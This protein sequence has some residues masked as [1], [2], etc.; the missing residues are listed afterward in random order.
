MVL[1]PGKIIE[2][3]YFPPEIRHMK[4]NGSPPPPRQPADLGTEEEN[5]RRALAASR[6]NASRAAS[7]LGLHRTTLWRKM[8]EFGIKREEFK[9]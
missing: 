6:G 3:N 2:P 1:I 5:I 4:T 8:R 7:D 9:G